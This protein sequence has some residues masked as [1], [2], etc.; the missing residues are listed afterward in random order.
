MFPPDQVDLP[1]PRDRTK[2]KLRKKIPVDCPNCLKSIQIGYMKRH[3]ESLHSK[4]MKQY[5]EF[6]AQLKH[7]RF[8]YPQTTPPLDDSANVQDEEECVEVLTSNEQSGELKQSSISRLREREQIPCQVCS[9]V[10][11]R[12]HMKRHV[13]IQHPGSDLIATGKFQAGKVVKTQ[14][15]NKK[16]SNSNST[17]EEEPSRRNKQSGQAEQTIPPDSQMKEA[18]KTCECGANFERL[19]YYQVHFTISHRS[20]SSLKRCE[21]AGCFG[22]FLN[23]QLLLNHKIGTH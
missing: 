11:Q 3:F 4:D 23:E 14:Q 20:F 9:R 5:I 1:K 12:K 15:V 19:V 6:R 17:T 8:S 16:T 22:L 10:L 2:E 18:V 7:Q 13:E 21:V